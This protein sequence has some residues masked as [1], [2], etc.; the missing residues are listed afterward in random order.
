[1]SPVHQEPNA[2]LC[3][4]VSQAEKQVLKPISV[5]TLDPTIKS[6]L[7]NDKKENKT[8]CD[9]N[10]NPIATE[11]DLQIP[12]CTASSSAA[13]HLVNNY[14]VSG[15]SD[16]DPFKDNTDSDPNYE[17]TENEE[18]ED[19]ANSVYEAP[20]PREPLGEHNDRNKD[21]KNKRK[22]K[23]AARSNVRKRSRNVLEWIDTK[24]KILLNQGVEHKNRKEKIIKERKM[25]T[26]C[27]EKCRLKCKTKINEEKRQLIFKEFWSTAD[28]TRQWDFIVRNVKEIKTKQV[29]VSA[30]SISRR[31]NSRNYSFKINKEEVKVCKAMFLNTLGIS[32]TWVT[33]A[34]SKIR[35]LT[36]LLADQRGKHNNRPE[37]I[38]EVIKDS[39]RNHIIMFPV[40]PSHYVRKDSK[41]MYLEEG[42][43]IKKMYRLY[44]DYCTDAQIIERATIRQYR[45]IFNEEFNISFFKP[46]KDQC[47]FCSV[48]SLSDDKK[49]LEIQREYDTHIKNKTLARELKDADKIIATDDKTVCVACF[50]LQKVLATPQSNVSDF[51]YKSK[52]STYNFTVYDVGNNEGFCYVWHEKIAKRG[53]CE[54]ASCLLKFIQTQKEKGVKS[55]IFYSDNCGGQNRNKF[56]FSMLSLASTTYQIDITHRFL[57]KG[58]TQNEGDSMHAVIENAKKRQSVLYV[59]EQWVTLIRMAKTTGRIY[60]V[61]EMSQNDFFNFKDITDIESWKTDE[62][63]KAFKISKIREVSV[64]SSAPVTIFF[65][66]VYDLAESD[67]LK[68]RFLESDKKRGRPLKAD[69]SHI[70]PNYL[71]RLYNAE[72]PVEE[73]KLKGLLWLCDKNKIPTMYHQFYRSLK[74]KKDSEDAELDEEFNNN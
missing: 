29:T 13:N 64:K 65:K 56:L 8:E 66:Y 42:L 27:K 10:S 72:L 38:K 43:N 71:K 54:I 46:K 14:C 26:A 16:E 20:A 22:R 61:T 70:L 44:T 15:E 68:I 69:K 19:N 21:K 45:D 67:I 48:Y 40:V 6:P 24:A 47:D 33:T 62:N 34:L 35:G 73:K 41:K 59:P 49:K 37:R 12:L 23:S 53:P 51:Y 4:E 57:E 60:N 74:C 39:V 31:L 28:H 17:P 18:S 58:H 30:G 63:K 2:T 50:D 5:S 36:T 55:I 25:G 52:Y 32:E 11:P 1:M 7:V 3:I 9:S